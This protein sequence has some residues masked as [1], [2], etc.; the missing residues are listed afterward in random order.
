MPLIRVSLGFMEMKDTE[1]DDFA[2]NVA[3]KLTENAATFGTLPVTPVQLTAAQTAFHNSLSAAKGAGKAATVDKDAK[4]ATLLGLLR[5][6]ALAIQ[7]KPGLTAEDVG[8][9]GL[10]AIVSGSH[11]PVAVDVPAIL[12]VINVASTKLGLKVKPPHGFKVI[13]VQ[14]AVGSNPPVLLGTFTNT[15]EM[16]LEK[17]VPATVY[18]LQAR[19]KFGNNRFGEW[20]EPVTHMCT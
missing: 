2:T 14:G 10:I 13:E 5:Q 12:D 3:A 19:A 6:I 15:R 16:V 8:L 1:L 20:S 7:G 11:A 4:R 18:S 9:G 17:L